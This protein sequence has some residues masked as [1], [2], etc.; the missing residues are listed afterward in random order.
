M[1]SLLRY[2]KTGII[3][4]CLVG[5]VNLCSQQVAAP[6]I[7]AKLYG[8]YPLPDSMSFAG[9]P[10]P[11][12]IPDVA[13]RLDRELQ[14]N[15]YFH[16]NT[17]LALKRMARFM[18]ELEMHLKQNNLP[19]DF[20][21]LVLAESLFGNVVSPKGAAGFW[22]LMPET[23]KGY[24]II[25]NDEIDE[26]YY[27]PKATVAA[28]TY[29]KRAKQKFGSWTNAAASY[30]RGM[31]GLERALATQHVSS[32]YDLYLN[33]ETFRYMFRILALKEVLEHPDRY[34]F[35]LRRIQGYAPPKTRLVTI[36]ESVPDLPQYALDL[37]INYKILKLHNPWISNYKLTVTDQI[38]SYEL[39]IPQTTP[40]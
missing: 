29:F 23:A 27:L 1:S 35:D 16:S 40:E 12:H 9:E 10:V 14:S 19:A 3:F 33:E 34:G 22:Q 17:I 11:L 25:I 8:S 4:I 5:T 32:Y 31:G 6:E 15:A 30:N 26:R 37:G 39:R 21:Y 20:K 28:A 24:K 2:W 38:T 7:T 18:P 36:T 13:E